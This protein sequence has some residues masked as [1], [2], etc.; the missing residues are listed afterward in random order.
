MAIAPQNAGVSTVNVK[1][2]GDPTPAPLGRTRN[3]VEITKEA[4]FLDV[5]GDR[6]GGDDGPPIEVQYLGE[7]ARVRM[8]LTE[9]DD[10]VA[11]KI[12][13]RLRAG[14]AG[15][16]GTPGGFMFAADLGLRLTIKNANDPRNFNRA[17]PRMPIEIGRGTKYSTL[18][19]EFECH[20]D[21]N[22]TLY[23]T[24]ETDATNPA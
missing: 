23:D 24:D 5:P 19:L 10:T 4:F 9:Y 13:A 7:I 22:G 1:Y 8:E 2:T 16:P 12:R 18:I 20:E 3:Y 17:F 6:F 14:T 21:G 11:D 15:V